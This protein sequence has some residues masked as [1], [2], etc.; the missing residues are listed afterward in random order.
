MIENLIER[1]AL[2]V[3]NHSAGKDSQ[4]MTIRLRKLVPAEQMLVIHADLGEVE[5]RGN[6][7]H[8]KSTIGDLPLIV[9]RNENRTFLDMVEQRGM[10]PSPSQRQCTSDQK[11]NPIE[12]EIRRYLK[13]KPQFGGL[14]VNCMGIRAAESPARS[15]QT[16]FR[17]VDGNSLGGREWYNWLPIFELSTE[18]VFA[19]IAAAGEVPHWAYAGGMSRLS[20]VF[21][22]MASRA[23]LRT[24]AALNPDLYRRY[25]ELEKRIGHTMSME[26]RPL[27]E[28]TG[29]PV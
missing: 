10:W 11:R 2:F 6:I 16:P 28:V 8:I 9:C 15:K 29:I 18:E 21:C 26:R 5:W 20:C 25:V 19:A 1:G 22:I 24:A 27:E 23:D 3:I 12:R 14:V 17:K 13:A 4:A 7:E